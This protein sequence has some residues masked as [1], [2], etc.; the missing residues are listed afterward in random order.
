VTS[1]GLGETETAVR[2]LALARDNSTRTEARDR[3][4]AKLSHLKRQR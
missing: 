3:Y 1:L 4:A 2:E